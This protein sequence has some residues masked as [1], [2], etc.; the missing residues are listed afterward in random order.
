MNDKYKITEL[1][2]GTQYIRDENGCLR[3]VKKYKNKLE[4]EIKNYKEEIKKTLKQG[5]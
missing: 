1:T 3:N 4:K 2:D 5:K